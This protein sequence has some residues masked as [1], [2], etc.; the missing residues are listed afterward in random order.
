MRQ[1]WIEAALNGPWSRT[2][3]PEIPDTIEAIIADGIACA[4]AGATIIHTHAYDGG[5]PQTFDWEVYAR[6]IEGIRAQVD[7]PVYPSYPAILTTGIDATFSMAAT[8]RFAHI[9]ALAARGLLE[10]A[11]IDPGS[12]NFTLTATTSGATPAGTYINPESHV[13]HALDFA[14]RLGLHPAFAIYEPGFMRAGAA[15]ARAAG[16]KT[17]IYRFMFS[18]QFAFGFPPK[19]YALAAHLAL[20][21]EAAGPAPWM[22]AGL[23][24]DIHPL[25][26]EA[27]ARGG[28]VR[29]G[30]EDAR[31][32]TPTGNL[33]RVEQ[34]V[35]LVRDHGGEPASVAEFRQALGNLA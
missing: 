14:A 21:E 17:P 28:H 9:E 27:V 7:V 19:P 32:G 2:L 3:Q 25:I 23:G 34:A 15:L 33:A 8:D 13:R 24:A 29:V 30:L 1:V 10:F 11:V 31:L 26:G 20:L 5:G 16:V 35:R 22:I 18:D 12:V 6:I 4:R